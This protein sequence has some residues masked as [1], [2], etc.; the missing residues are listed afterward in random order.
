MS[1]EDLWLGI[2][3]CRVQAWV[4]PVQCSGWNQCQIVCLHHGFRTS[5]CGSDLSLL[6]IQSPGRSLTL[7]NVAFCEE[8]EE[9]RLNSSMCKSPGGQGYVKTHKSRPHSENCKRF[10]CAIQWALPATNGSASA[11]EVGEQST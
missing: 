11:F 8:A 6:L 1:Q 3:D 10:L 5:H 2:A 9:E 7:S 4:S